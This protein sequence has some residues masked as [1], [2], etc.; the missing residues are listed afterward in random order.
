V[1]KEKGFLK[2]FILSLKGFIYNFTIYKPQRVRSS[3]Y[4]PYRYKNYLYRPYRGVLSV[5]RSY[6]GVLYV[7]RPYRS[8]FISHP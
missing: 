6:M 7:L 8:T 2:G 1:D 3:F 4:R 5:L